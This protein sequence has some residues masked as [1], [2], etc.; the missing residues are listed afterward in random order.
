MSSARLKSLLR[1]WAKD[2]SGTAAIE[3]GILGPVFLAMTCG[4]MFL[5]VF[6]FNANRIDSAAFEA[7]RQVML[8]NEPTIANL[9]AEVTS[10]FNQ[11]DLDGS[12]YSVS[13]GQ[14][15]DGGDEAIIT[16][17]YTMLDPTAFLNTEG[18]THNVEYRV[19]LWEN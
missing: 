16:A 14:R 6:L 3:F 4:I 1:S 9:Q 15:P 11:L 7:S 12:T 13:I 2:R 19:P 10:Q 5:G 18:F 17:S 8:V